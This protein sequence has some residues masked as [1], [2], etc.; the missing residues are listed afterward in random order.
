MFL[1]TFAWN[2][3]LC[4]FIETTFKTNAYFKYKFRDEQEGGTSRIL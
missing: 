2:L 1:V 3:K 4:V